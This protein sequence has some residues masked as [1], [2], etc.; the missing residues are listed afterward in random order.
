MGK[1]ELKGFEE[2]L[3]VLECL[4]G[5]VDA[6]LKKALYKG[7]GEMA[8]TVRS[9]INSIAAVP[10]VENVKAY[11]EGRKNRLGIKQK[12]GLIESMGITDFEK[13]DGGYSTKIGFDGYNDV[14]TKKYP[15]GQPNV[16]I[17][18]VLESGSTYMEKVPFMRKSLTKG[19]KKAEE[20]MRKQVEEEVSLLTKE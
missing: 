11:K 3:K 7:A 6:V 16:L 15:K 12:K 20:E 14:K 1:M 19:R 13:E 17:A 18:R 2:Y 9:E 5:N 10:D 8:D 4:G